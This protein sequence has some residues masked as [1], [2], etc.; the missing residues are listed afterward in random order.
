[1]KD[2]ITGKAVVCRV[3]GDWLHASEILSRVYSRE[4]IKTLRRGQP[5]LATLILQRQLIGSPCQMFRGQVQI[6]LLKIL[7]GEAAEAALTKNRQHG[8]PIFENRSESRNQPILL[9]VSNEAIAR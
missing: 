6:E 3:D 9:S 5:P 7:G 8:G 4:T 1:M 2:V